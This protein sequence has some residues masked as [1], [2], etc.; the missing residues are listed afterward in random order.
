M[1]HAGVAKDIPVGPLDGLLVAHR[2]RRQHAG[3][4]R[5]GHAA[6]DRVADVLA[7]APQGPPGPGAS[8]T[9]PAP[10]RERT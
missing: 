9:A 10:G 1:R 3:H 7:Q 8:R 2:Q 4:G 5:V 6:G